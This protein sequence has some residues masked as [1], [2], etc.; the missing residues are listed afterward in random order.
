MTKKNPQSTWEAVWELVKILQEKGVTSY[1]RFGKLEL[2][3]LEKE[4]EKIEE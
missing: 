2:V 3:D 4:A 1:S